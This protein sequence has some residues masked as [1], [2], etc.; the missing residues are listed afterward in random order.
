MPTDID[1]MS[2]A[3]LDALR[4]RLHISQAELCRAALLT[5]AAYTKWLRHLLGKPKGNPPQRRSLEA[6]RSALKNQVSLITRQL[7]PS[8]GASP[9]PPS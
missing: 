2:F 7:P 4:E 6:L 9:A 8:G 1:D 5:P 3:E